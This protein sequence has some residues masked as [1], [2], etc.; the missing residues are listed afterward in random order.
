MNEEYLKSYKDELV[1]LLDGEDYMRSEQFAKNMMMSQEIKANNT[2]EGINDDLSMIDEVI[3]T[4]EYLSNRERK[5]IINL[6][7]GYHY[8]LNHK[9]IDKEHLR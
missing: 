5:R 9:V 2:I 7:H 4:K 3:K 1:R 6:Y 8:I